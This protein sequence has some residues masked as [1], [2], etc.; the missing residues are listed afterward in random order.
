MRLHEITEGILDPDQEFMQRFTYAV[1]DAAREYAEFLKD[2]NDQDDPE[3]LASILETFFEEEDL[4]ITV[5]VGESGRNA[6]DWYIQAAQVT[7]SGEMDLILDPDSIDGHWGPETFID[8][9]T[10]TFEHETIHLQQRDRMGADKYNKLPS[11][12]MKGLKKAEKTGKERDLMRTYFRDPQELMA[13]GHDIYRE[14]IKLSD[15]EAALRNPEKH[16]EDLPTYDK[17][18][19]I[20]PPNAKPLQRM[21]KYAYQYF[22]KNA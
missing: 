9:M 7:G 21:M 14:V 19:Q 22:Q 6:V 2:N 16:R 3:E 5:H 18:R 11:G 8:V 10:K 4:P 12:Y 15:P 1:E 20:F 17:H 13:H